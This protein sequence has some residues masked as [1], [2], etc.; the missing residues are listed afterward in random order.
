MYGRRTEYCEQ[1]FTE[2]DRKVDFQN[3]LF[4]WILFENRFFKLLNKDDKNV[5]KFLQ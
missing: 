4:G 5:T 1:I 2:F 3:H